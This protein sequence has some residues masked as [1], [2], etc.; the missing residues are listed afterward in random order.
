MEDA[1]TTSVIIPTKDRV[2][3]IL[4]C[5]DSILKQTNPVQEII[6]ID[7][8]ENTGLYSLLKEKFPH[9]IPKI[10]YTH[11][12]VSNNAARNIGIQ[13]S[14]G[15][16]VFFF[17]DDVILD[18]NYVK[19][20]VK[21]FRSDKEGKIAGVMGNITNMKRDVY[22]WRAMLKR[23]FYQDHFGDGKF[24]LSGLPTWVH[25]KRKIVRTEFL[26]GC[27]S[28]YRR[29]VLDK[30]KF[31]EKLGLLGGYC[32]LDDVDMSYRVSR[33]YTLMYTPLAKLEHHALGIISPTKRRQ[34]IF[35]HFYLFKKNVPKRLPN[36]FAFVLSLYGL[37]LFALLLQRNLKGFVSYLQGL[38]DITSKFP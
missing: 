31:D 12:K 28:A 8:S 19:E 33:R 21:V 14:T 29:E 34:Y 11:S 36:I 7:S 1:S 16:I 23:L 22:G 5:I 13:Q 17:D 6:I 3:E 10:K 20:I 26:S 4:G 2:K 27:M 24:R 9:A 37:L 32:F 18:K 35:N 15:G 38:A 25:G 30:F